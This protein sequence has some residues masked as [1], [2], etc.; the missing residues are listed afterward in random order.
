MRIPKYATIYGLTDVEGSAG[1][2]KGRAGVRTLDILSHDIRVKILRL[3]AGGLEAATVR[4]HPQTDYEEPDPDEPTFGIAPGGEEMLPIANSIEYWLL[5]APEGPMIYGEARTEDTIEALSEAWN[6]AFIHAFAHGPKTL[7]DLDR[8]V[9]TADRAQIE[10]L[11]L[12]MRRAG[13]VQ[14]RSGEGESAVYEGTEWL[15]RAIAP[16]AL[17]ARADRRQ[18]GDE[19][20]PI[21]ALDVESGLLMALPLVPMPKGVSGTCR[22]AVAMEEGPAAP[23]VGVTVA[24]AEGGVVSCNPGLDLD[25]SAEVTGDLRAW[26]DAVLDEQISR[27]TY[28]GD[29]SV[30][31]TLIKRL[32]EILYVAG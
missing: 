8:A 9:K 5:R 17:A 15:R 31:R 1:R 13:A 4:I 28:S 10:Q 27:L 26:G 23:L 3:M 12:R 18:F 22:L 6:I 11:L 14:L 29:R 21:D 7:A 20:M 32:H 16:L 30:G 25:T 19:T 24:V 2:K